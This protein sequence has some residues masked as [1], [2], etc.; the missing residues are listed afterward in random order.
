M[1]QR[2]AVVIEKIARYTLV[3]GESASIYLETA[4][5]LE[6]GGVTE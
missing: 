5:L 3:S 1:S 6:A 4:D 2:D